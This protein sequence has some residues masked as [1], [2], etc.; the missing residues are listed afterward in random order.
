M[1]CTLQS[2]FQKG[3][4][5]IKLMNQKNKFG[6]AV[7]LKTRHVFRG[8]GVQYF[9]GHVIQLHYSIHYNIRLTYFKQ[10]SVTVLDL[11]PFWMGE[12]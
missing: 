7:D 4:L 6:Y 8:L 11:L 12:I 5:L 9:R 10:K 1:S 2:K 3:F